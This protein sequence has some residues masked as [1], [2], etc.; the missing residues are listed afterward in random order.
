M[1]LMHLTKRELVD[2]VLALENRLKRCSCSEEGLQFSGQVR[3]NRSLQEGGASSVAVECETQLAK[4][5]DEVQFKREVLHQLK[6]IKDCLEISERKVVD[7]VREN[8]LNC[9]LQLE[10]YIGIQDYL[11]S[12]S[13][14]L[15][16]HGW[17]L[18]SDIA[19]YLLRKIS[20][21]DYDFVFEFGSGTSTVLLAKAIQALSLETADASQTGLVTFEHLEKY[22]EKTMALLQDHGVAD[23]VDLKLAPLKRMDVGGRE[24]YYYDCRESIAKM[25]SRY[26][27]VASKIMV[28]VDGPPASTCALARYPALP[29][30]LEEFRSQEIHFVMDDFD[31][32]E[33]REVAEEWERWLRNASRKYTVEEIGFEKGAAVVTVMPDRVQK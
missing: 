6:S 17:P 1:S 25:S 13:M 24:Y 30:I 29:V 22:H 26:G 21:E 20:M 12:G 3:A 33:E 9:I 2:R 32:K 8:S 15:D 16:F 19:L 23:F 18:S 31:R 14:A 7:K 11:R 10:S 28:L 5:D 27:S 4:D